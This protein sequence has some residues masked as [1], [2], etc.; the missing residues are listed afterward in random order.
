M[1]NPLY[2]WRNEG[3]IWLTNLLF[4]RGDISRAVADEILGAFASKKISMIDGPI[5]FTNSREMIKLLDIAARKG[6]VS[7]KTTYFGCTVHEQILMFAHILVA[8]SKESL[9]C[10]PQIRDLDQST[11]NVLSGSPCCPT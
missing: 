10:N 1:N 7:I 3:E 5:Q 2:L 8:F 4:R 11:G 6:V 9:Q